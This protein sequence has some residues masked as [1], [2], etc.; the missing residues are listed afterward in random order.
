M[1]SLLPLPFLQV[2]DYSQTSFMDFHWLGQ[3]ISAQCCISYRI[4]FFYLIRK[5]NLLVS[6][7]NATLTRLALYTIIGSTI[8]F[9]CFRLHIGSCYFWNKVLSSSQLVFTCSKSRETPEQYVKSN[10]RYQS[11]L[12][13]VII[14]LFLPWTDFTHSSGVC[15]VNCSLSTSKSSLDSFRTITE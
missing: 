1:L 11:D 9:F 5:S 6:I 3:H 15:I 8:W 13:Y 10:T 14:C 7:W 12:T 4:Q 2:F